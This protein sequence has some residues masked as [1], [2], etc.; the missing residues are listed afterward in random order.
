[1]YVHKRITGII[2]S[3]TTI[4][5]GTP[6]FCTLCSTERSCVGKFPNSSDVRD[7][8][9]KEED[10]QFNGWWVKEY[11]TMNAMDKFILFFPYILLILAAVVVLIERLFQK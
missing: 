8:V 7:F 11:C 2:V 9:P 10:P 5:T 1:M 6:L 3:P 4:I